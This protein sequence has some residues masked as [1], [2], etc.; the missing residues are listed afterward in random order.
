MKVIVVYATITGNNEAIADILIEQFQN[1]SVVATK[2][3]ISQTDPKDLK[4]FDLAIIV[5]YTYDLGSIPSE[6][7]DFFD[8]LLKTDLSNLNFVVVGSGDTFYGE[9]NYGGAVDLFDQQMEKTQAHR[10]HDKIKIDRYPD[11]NDQKTLTE[12]VSKLI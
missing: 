12:L 2:S 7:Y 11:E 8:D 5:P 9:K 1:K 4:E 6:G 10:Q 3:E